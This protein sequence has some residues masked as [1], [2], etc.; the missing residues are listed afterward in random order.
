[1]LWRKHSCTDV[2]GAILDPRFCRLGSSRIQLANTWHI[3]AEIE[4][5]LPAAARTPSTLLKSHNSGEIC[6]VT[7]VDEA[8]LSKPFALEKGFQRIPQDIVKSVAAQDAPNPYQA[9]ASRYSR[10]AEWFLMVS[11]ASTKTSLISGCRSPS[12]RVN[13]SPSRSVLDHGDSSGSITLNCISS[14][15]S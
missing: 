7:A 13:I 2:E 5:K 15:A 11:S 10:T 3:H 8:R 14:T 1:M 6:A 4:G 9:N 12:S